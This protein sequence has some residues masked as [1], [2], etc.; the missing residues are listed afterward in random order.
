MN[1]LKKKIIIKLPNR[2]KKFQQED[3]PSKNPPINAK[4]RV[5]IQNH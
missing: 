1:R 4:V 5:K 2:R 3:E